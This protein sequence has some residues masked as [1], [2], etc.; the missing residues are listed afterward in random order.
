MLFY[1]DVDSASSRGVSPRRSGSRTQVTSCEPSPHS[2]WLVKLRLEPVIGQWKGKVGL[3]ILEREEGGCNRT[4][5]PGEA[6]K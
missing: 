4:T 5:W 2:N 3:E 6:L 1:S